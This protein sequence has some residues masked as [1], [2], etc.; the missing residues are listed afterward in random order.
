VTQEGATE[1]LDVSIWFDVG[2]HVRGRL[3]PTLQPVRTVLH[4]SPATT[5]HSCRGREQISN[6]GRSHGL[7]PR[8]RVLRF[9][10]RGVR[11]RVGTRPS[12]PVRLYMGFDVDLRRVS[13]SRGVRCVLPTCPSAYGSTPDAKAL[14]EEILSES[15][16]LAM[17]TRYR[18][19]CVDVPCLGFVMGVS[20][21][22]PSRMGAA[23]DGCCLR[24]FV[25]RTTVAR[26]GHPQHVE[27]R[28]VPEG[29]PRPDRFDAADAEAH[30]DVTKSKTSFGVCPRGSGRGESP[31]HGRTL[32]ERDFDLEV[33][34]GS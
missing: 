26:R 2:D 20:D 4:R 13:A 34:R 1:V 25:L 28:S 22:S 8:R 6:H 12:L 33:E 15:H 19:G 32:T 30:G 29:R 18:L 16:R 21:P 9:S 31:R 17:G 27:S 11:D 24:G 10:G 3:Q 23:V 14:D 7:D 5:P